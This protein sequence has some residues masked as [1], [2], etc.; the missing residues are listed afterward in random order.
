[1]A[2]NL[3]NPPASASPAS[4]RVTACTITP[5]RE[6]KHFQWVTSVLVLST[7]NGFFIISVSLRTA[8]HPVPS[9]ASLPGPPAPGPEARLSPGR[10]SGTLLCVF[11]VLFSEVPA[12]VTL[13]FFSLCG[14]TSTLWRCSHRMSYR[15]SSQIGKLR[16]ARAWCPGSGKGGGRS[17]DSLSLSPGL[18]RP[19]PCLARTLAGGVYVVLATF[20]E[21]PGLL[22]LALG[23]SCHKPQ[24]AR[25]ASSLLVGAC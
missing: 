9:G 14:Y 13:H 17:V 19:S 11:G 3:W 25:P 23:R 22:T 15:V 18:L 5:T 6:R 7:E 4:A 20:S 1:M 8:C 21:A 12:C 2:S 16:L 10:L 24:A